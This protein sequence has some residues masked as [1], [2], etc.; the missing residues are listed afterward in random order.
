LDKLLFEEILPVDQQ[1][2]TG[3]QVFANESKAFRPLY[4]VV[5]RTGSVEATYFGG[6]VYYEEFGPAPL[7]LV[8][9]L[10]TDTSSIR[11]GK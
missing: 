5:G 6:V 11:V 4:E 8:V 3:G 2:V 10:D 1:Q 9:A 7:T